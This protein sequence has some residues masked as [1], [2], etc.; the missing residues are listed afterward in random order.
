MSDVDHYEEE[1]QQQ[2]QPQDVQ[3]VATA[4]AAEVTVA[5][6]EMTLHVSAWAGKVARP[7]APNAATVASVRQ[8]RQDMLN[9]QTTRADDDLTAA[10][11]QTREA[12][13]AKGKAFGAWGVLRGAVLKGAA[14]AAAATTRGVEAAVSKV[15][16]VRFSRSFPEAASDEILAIFSCQALHDGMP[17]SGTVFVTDKRL[18]Y[19]NGGT[20]RAAILH[21]EMVS[22]SL[23][24]ALAT[25]EGRPHLIP[26]PEIEVLADSLQVFLADKRV[27]E[28]I[29]ITP[30]AGEA[31]SEITNHRFKHNQAAAML[32]ASLYDAWTKTVG[33]VPLEGVD[34]SDQ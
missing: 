13:D 11:Q 12:Q 1:E 17:I 30:D 18:C 19:T 32:H 14:Q 34:Y 10:L 16:S 27:V 3:P 23:C 8:A 5:P 26:R 4:T 33:D 7:V 15:A 6:G 20:I 9:S 22:V 29:H 28:L 31:A 21:S 2:Q 24:L 25:Y